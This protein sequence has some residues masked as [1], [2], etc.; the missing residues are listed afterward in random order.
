[1]YC[2][3]LSQPDHEGYQ[4]AW[5]PS[6]F[7]QNNIVNKVCSLNTFPLWVK[8]NANQNQGTAVTNSSP[9]LSC[10]HSY[11]GLASSFGKCGLENR[12]IEAQDRQCYEAF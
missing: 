1:M 11:R 5:V 12:L 4:T 10:L 6:T 9:R 3:W 8:L 7:D 2:R